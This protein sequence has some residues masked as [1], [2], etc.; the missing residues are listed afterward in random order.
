MSNTVLVAN[1]GEIACRVIRAAKKL[2]LR[3]VAVYSEADADLPH[4]SL[5]DTAV[6]LGPARA[7]DSYLRADKLIEAARTTGATLVHPGYGFLSERPAFAQAC[8]DAGMSFVGPTADVIRLMGD[9]DQA[10]RAAAAAG[11][12]VLPGTGKLDPTDDRALCEAGAA[13]GYP[14]LVKAAAGGGGIGMRTVNNADELVEAVRATSGM[15]LKEIG[16]AHV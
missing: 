11:V 4:V 9:K 16:R 10:R 1:R 8:V 6:L 2:N 15:A 7:A 12:P 5:A 13:T 14:L 3:T